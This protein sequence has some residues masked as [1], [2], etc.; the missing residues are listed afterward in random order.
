MFSDEQLLDML[1]NQPEIGFGLLMDQYI[2]LVY[3]IVRSKLINVASSEDIEEC[4]SD[5]FYEFY[6]N[7]DSLDLTKGTIKAF[8]SIIA[9]RKAIRQF[10]KLVRLSQNYLNEELEA[11]R[12]NSQEDVVSTLIDR[13]V[14]ADLV[15]EINALGEPDNEIFIRKY[16]MG[17]STKAIAEALQIK[18]NTVDKK[19][20]RGL[21]RLQ[22][23][24]GGI[25]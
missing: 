6:Q 21:H 18:A 24:I 10:H 11:D 9:K 22:N 20:S 7:R 25:L 19:I 5:I 12:I 1:T 14:K 2:G 16:F 23:S 13:E 17:Q 4:T 15:K 8:L 3:T